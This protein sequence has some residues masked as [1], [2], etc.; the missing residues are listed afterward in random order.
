[1][2][3]DLDTM[4][5][6]TKYPIIIA[7]LVDGVIAICGKGGAHVALRPYEYHHVKTAGMEWKALEKGAFRLPEGYSENSLN[8]HSEF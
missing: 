7:A 5:A 2:C 6:R 1:M 8:S 3:A 4:P